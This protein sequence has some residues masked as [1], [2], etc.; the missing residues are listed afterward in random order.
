MPPL[1][2]LEHWRDKQAQAEREQRELPRL[3]EACEEEEDND[4]D[5]RDREAQ[6]TSPRHEHQEVSPHS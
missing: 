2:W 4:V 1:C 5:E 3:E 6:A